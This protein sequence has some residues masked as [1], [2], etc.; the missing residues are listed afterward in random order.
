MRDAA[1]AFSSEWLIRSREENT[2]RPDIEARSRRDSRRL[3]ARSMRNPPNRQSD[4]RVPGQR[5]PHLQIVECSFI[6]F[7]PPHSWRNQVLK[8]SKLRGIAYIPGLNTGDPI[9]V[10]I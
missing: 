2:I 4:P 6:P 5:K 1:G 7:I 3:R 10:M 9:W 8:R